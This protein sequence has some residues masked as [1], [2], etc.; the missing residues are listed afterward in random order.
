MTQPTSVAAIQRAGKP[1]G[2]L[3]QH[4]LVGAN[5]ARQTGA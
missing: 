3:A 4:L 2:I 1:F 5:P